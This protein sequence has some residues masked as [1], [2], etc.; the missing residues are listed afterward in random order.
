MK[1]FYTTA[2]AMNVFS[3]VYKDVYKQRIDLYD[4][5]SDKRVRELD[6]GKAPVMGIVASAGFSFDGKL[7]AM[8]GFEKKERSVLI[9]ETE[10][11]PQ[12]KHFSDQ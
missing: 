1:E 2:N 9:Y 8:T 12:G 4:G 10:N 3:D 6:G 11:G 7:V 5:Q